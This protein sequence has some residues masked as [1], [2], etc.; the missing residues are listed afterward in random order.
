[1]RT[2][3]QDFLNKLPVA[4]KALAAFISLLIPFLTAIVA[5]L[6][7][8]KVYASEWTTIL[9]AGGAVVAGTKSVYQV[10]NRTL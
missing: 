9:V 1:M 10:K 4:Y 6:S 3:M 2:I 5:A 8:G 7:D